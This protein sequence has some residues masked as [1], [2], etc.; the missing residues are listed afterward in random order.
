MAAMIDAILQA[1]HVRRGEARK[2]LLLALYLFL[3][4]STFITGRIS[5]DSL[6]LS[7]FQKEHLAYMYISVALMVPLPAYLYARIADR[8][9]RDRLLITALLIT[10]VGMGICRLL[11][12]TGKSWVFVV[13]Y[14]FVE[15][16]GTFLILQFWTFAGDLFSSRE[17]KRL[18]PFIGAGSVVAGIVCGVAISAIVP[19]VGTE[20][21]L[22]LQMLLL[23][24]GAGVIGRVGSME[25][26]RLQEA[27]LVKQVRK[28]KNGVRFRVS[29]EAASVFASKHLKIIAGITVATFVTVPL[30]DYQ[31]KVALK[32]HFTV[33]GVVNTDA[34]S[35]FMGLFS[36]ATGALA[37]VIQLAITSRVLER[38]GVVAALIVL[39][40]A[41]FLGLS[42]LLLG[43]GTVLVCAVLLKGA[44]NTFR[45]SITDA[46]M[47]VLYTPVPAQVRG[48]AKT[49]IDGIVKPVAGGLAGAAMVLVVGPL[50]LPVQSLAA[51]ALALT[52]AWAMLVLL[53]G[54]EYVHELLA[55]LRRRRLDFSDQSL[56]I[57]DEPTVMLLRQR[58]RSSDVAEVRSALELAK[59][60]D[61]HDMSGELIPLLKHQDADLRMQAAEIL[62]GS[63]ATT[64]ASE[65][66]RLFCEDPVD[67][68]RGAAISA[69]CALVGESALRVV[70]PYL[71]SEAPGVRAAAVAGIIRHGG[72]DG[73]L[74]AADDLKAMLSGTEEGVRFAAANVLRDIAVK[75]FFQPVLTLLRDP[76]P[77]VQNAAIQAAGAMRSPELVPAL[78]YKLQG[79]ETA[80]TAAL[81]LTS[82]GEG[83]ID[84]LAKVL[85]Q[86]RE[87]PT[88]RRQVPRI[89]ERIGTTRCLDV[90]LA[91]LHTLD[92]G[93]RRE[94]ARA[95]GRLRERLGIIVDDKLVRRLIDEELREQYQHLAA[96][97][98]LAG[99]ADDARRDLLR[100]AIEERLARNLDRVF[101]L[102][103]I[104]HSV[105]AIDT[106]HANLR[107]SSPTIRAN[108]VEVLDNFLDVDLKR[109]LL[110]LIEDM[111]LP[112]TLARGAELYQLER[113]SPEGWVQQFL[114]GRDPWLVVCSLHVT[115]ELGLSSLLP[116]VE[117]HRGHADPI[118]RET[119]LRTLAVLCRPE[120]FLEKCAPLRVDDSAV[121]R[122]AATALLDE[123]RRI[124]D[125]IADSPLPQAAPTAQAQTG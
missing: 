22:F 13:L 109:R 71:H 49:F 76:S 104:I 42:S 46:T 3:A 20:N 1:L 7:V 90:L 117:P 79:R 17:A 11:L 33:N 65:L 63:G 28:Q 119:A 31:F 73:I 115:A 85:L 10:V 60:V 48:R 107:S 30:I 61:G 99:V 6:F 101:R 29:L 41:L 97:D 118:V 39:P 68:V 105:K 77:R 14:N 23:L 111:P 51:I 82:F 108:A 9:R 66:E 52:A 103:S 86:D 88:V 80:R 12:H 21:L 89:L 75:S 16:Y 92:P 4:V 47:Q 124:V 84:V 34:M 91:G 19:I 102:L 69:Y 8:F 37:A 44:E 96:I 78:I 18:F 121:V 56:V 122:R 57:T 5:R 38:F 32:D 125:R 87:E 25:R 94:V 95:T 54:R 120:A 50:G 15:V 98:D 112:A 58:L 26:T 113:R 106:I 81:A 64:T 55:T 114:C 67:A 45:Y 27:V 72:L 59:R 83:V 35:S 62:G 24:G 53:I 43:V 93:T 40:I 100:D 110:P 123:A 74:A 70:E 2:V 116:H 36:A